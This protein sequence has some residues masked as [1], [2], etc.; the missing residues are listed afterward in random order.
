[1]KR[2]GEFW[3]YFHAKIQDVQREYK[4]NPARAA[5]RG[6]FE[7]FSLEI[8]RKYKGNP[9]RAARRGGFWG[10]FIGNVEELQR[11]SGARSAPGVT[12]GVLLKIQR[13][14]KDFRRAQRA[15]GFVGCFH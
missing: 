5:R 13:N 11:Q 10:V 1:M 12:F 15:G 9:A 7:A 3:K 6:D 8:Q 14:A 2:A 4:G